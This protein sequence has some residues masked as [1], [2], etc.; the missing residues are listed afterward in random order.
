M[1]M[2]ERHMAWTGLLLLPVLAPVTRAQSLAGAGSDEQDVVQRLQDV[3]QEL[4]ELRALS[5]QSA[6]GLHRF[7]ISGFGS[8][9]F[10]NAEGSDSSFRAAFNPIFLYEMG[11]RF[12]FETELEIGVGGG[13]HG[14]HGGGETEVELGYAHGSYIVNDHVIVGAGKFLTPFGIFSERIHPSWINKLP[15]APLHAGH[16]GILP[17]SSLGAYVRGGLDVG[18]DKLNYSAYVSNGPRLN[19]GEDEPEEA[20]MLHFDNFN[21][22]NND[23]AFGL[24]LGYLPTSELEI[25]ASYMRSAVTPGMSDVEDADADLFGLDV[26]YDHQLGGGRLSLRAEYAWSTVDDVTYDADGSLGFGP[27][28]FDNE[29]EGGYLQLSYRMG[30]SDGVLLSPWELVGRYDVLDNPDDAEESFD[31]D[32][33]LLGVNYWLG[34][35]SVVKL[36]YVFD[37]KDGVGVTDA[38]AVLVQ[39][40]FGF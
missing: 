23:K 39:F 38:D 36:A 28:E 4:R 22:V 2:R 12:L 32:R 15:I 19:D 31:Q 25:G 6:P 30:G 37:D 17:M 34:A 7:L 14:G 16:G 11:E 5:E 3:E 40:A 24:R 20:G 26:S 33:F 27:L 10:E 9:T 1:S 8:T 21:D 29:R 35:T 18:S 13:G